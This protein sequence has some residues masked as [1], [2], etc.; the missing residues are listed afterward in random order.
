MIKMKKDRINIIFA[1]CILIVCFFVLVGCRT[2]TPTTPTT[3]TE[4]KTIIQ[5]DT[6]IVFDTIVKVRPDSSLLVLYAECDSNNS[7]LL[8]ELKAMQGARAKIKYE[9][10]DNYINVECLCDSLE[11]EVEKQKT[12]NKYITEQ[13]I[14]QQ[15]IITEKDSFIKRLGWICI[16]MLLML[17]VML[18]LI[19]K[20]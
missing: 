14:E 11:L 19:F 9:C 3:K 15:K 2:T 7:L 17:I 18:I 6:T 20:R 1:I 12:I 5:R 10:I 13:Y 4:I 8:S 16:G